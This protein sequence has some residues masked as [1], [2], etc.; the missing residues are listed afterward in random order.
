MAARNNDLEKIIQLFLDEIK[1]TYRLDCA[2]LLQSSSSWSN[3]PETK[4]FISKA[5]FGRKPL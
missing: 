3:W 2:Y 5:T 1:R 4:E